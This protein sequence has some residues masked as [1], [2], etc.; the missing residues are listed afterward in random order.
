MMASQ[1]L[2][3][4]INGYYYSWDCNNI[5]SRMTMCFAA[6]DSPDRSGRPV[7]HDH[8]AAPKGDDML[9]RP[10]LFDLVL[11]RYAPR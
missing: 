5:E 4:L 10:G 7:V 2:E 1:D 8:E 6:S 3:V 9:P 11:S